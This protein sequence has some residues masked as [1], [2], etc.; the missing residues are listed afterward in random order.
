MYR[1]AVLVLALTL[2]PAFAAAQQPCTT[3]A[4]QV[5]SE[6]Y[7]H[8]LER[9]ADSGSAHWMQQLQSGRMTVR[10]VV[11]EIAKSPEYTQR[12]WRQETGEEAPYIRA[13]GRLYRH[14]LGRQPDAAGARVWAERAAQQGAVAVIDQITSSN[15]YNNAFGDWGVPGSG[16]LRYCGPNNQGASMTSSAPQPQINSPTLARRFR[17]MDRN[18]DGVLSRSE[19]RGSAQAFENRDWNNDNVLSGDEVQPGAARRGRTRAFDD[20]FDDNND[21]VL[22]DVNNNG[23]IELRE[24]DG[25]AAAFDRLDLNNDNVLGRNEFVGDRAVVTATTGDLIVV[26]ASQEW[27]DTGIVV[28]RGDMLVFEAQGSVRLSADSN[29]VAN[30]AGHQ[31]GRRAGAAPLTQVAAGTLIARIGNDV[32][33]IGDRRSLRSPASG[34]LYLSVNDDHHADNSGEYRVSVDIQNR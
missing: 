25:T 9:S 22:L 10:D 17:N 27:T 19:W 29:D 28:R 14:L 6:L 20:N 12:F 1:A 5:V 3:D 8:M 21:F 33:S 11:R 13:V 34:R 26:D 32:M 30:P 16:G 15:E 18:N 4:N 7:R 23:R 2:V 31:S 24:W